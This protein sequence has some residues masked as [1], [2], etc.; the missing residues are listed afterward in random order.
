MKNKREQREKEHEP[1]IPPLTRDSRTERERKKNGACFLFISLP[2]FLLSFLSLRSSYALS[3]FFS[4]F[5]FLFNLNTNE[6][7]WSAWFKLKEKGKGRT[8]DCAVF[9]FIE[10]NTRS[11]R[12][13]VLIQLKRTQH[14]SWKDEWA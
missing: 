10:L 1:P 2:P 9:F 14:K 6:M 8:N 7:K 11:L 12:L 3:S 5:L 13:L 4:F